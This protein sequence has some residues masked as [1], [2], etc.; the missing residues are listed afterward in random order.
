MH[1]EV[2]NC[3]VFKADCSPRDADDKSLP[4]NSYLVTYIENDE[5]KYDIVISNKRVSIFDFYYDQ[6]KS[7]KNSK[8]VCIEWTKGNCNPKTWINPNVPSPPKK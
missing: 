2:Y 6:L 3:K 1:N 7:L 5:L 8:V 4:K